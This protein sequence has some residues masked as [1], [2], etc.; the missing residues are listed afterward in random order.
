M[1]LA[2]A[3]EKGLVTICELLID[4]GADVRDAEHVR[5]RQ[6]AVIRNRDNDIV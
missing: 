1:A 6:L 3:A 5:K 4:M 2:C